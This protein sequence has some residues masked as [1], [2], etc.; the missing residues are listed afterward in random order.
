[1]SEYLG[2]LRYVCKISSQSESSTQFK[3]LGHFQNL[4]LSTASTNDKCYFAIPGLDLVNKGLRAM[5]IFRKLSW[6]KIFAN[7]P[8]MDTQNLKLGKA[9]TKTNSIWQPLGLDLVNINEYAKFHHNIPL[10]SRD[11]TIF[12][13]W[14]STQPQPMI[15]VILQSLGLDLVNIYVVAI[16]YQN[17][18]NCL[19]VMGIFWKLSGDKIFANCPGTDKF[20]YRAHSESQPLVSLPV[21]FF[22]VVQYQKPSVHTEDYKNL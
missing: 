13:L 15:N 4:E 20:D 2:N 14:S 12:T 22:R 6:D 16:Y 11:R 5:G 10:S 18:P 3:R 7:W 1:M 19:R 21:D 9:S 8:V 17:I